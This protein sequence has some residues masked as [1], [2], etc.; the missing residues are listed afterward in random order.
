MF[1]QVNPALDVKEYVKLENCQKTK[2]GIPK[3]KT[4]MD[5]MTNYINQIL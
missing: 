2:I 1:V 3:I 5:F 4:F